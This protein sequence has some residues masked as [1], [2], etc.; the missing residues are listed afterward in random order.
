MMRS[1]VGMLGSMLWIIWYDM[2]GWDDLG[3][4]C[5]VVI[6]LLEKGV[7]VGRGVLLGGVDWDWGCWKYV[8]CTMVV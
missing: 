2:V 7:Y 4:W 3:C 5:R 6:G 1:Q 8:E